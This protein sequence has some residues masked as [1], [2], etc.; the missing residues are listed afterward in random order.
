MNP[1]YISAGLRTP[2]V[3]T[4]G[5]FAN[6]TALELSIPVAKAMANIATPDFLV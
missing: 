5:P 6:Y 2:F 1:I 4:G 3:K